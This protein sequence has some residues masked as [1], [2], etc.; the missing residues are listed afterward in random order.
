MTRALS[1]M[2]AGLAAA[3]LSSGQANA[4]DLD[5]LTRLLIPGY[6]AQDFASAC[7]LE[8]ARFLAGGIDGYDSIAAYAEHLKKEITSNLSEKDA[9]KVRL[10]AAN[11]ALDVARSELHK[12]TTQRARPP[13]EAVREWCDSAARSFIIGLVSTH[14]KQH[15]KFDVLVRN[16]TS[17]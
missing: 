3:S 16:A 7:S 4:R 15:Q 5:L 1:C 14:V 8:D 12:L 13:K 17:E 10:A 2:I 9:S 6:I 11:V